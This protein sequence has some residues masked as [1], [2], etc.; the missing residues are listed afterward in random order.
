LQRAGIAAQILA[1]LDPMPVPVFADTP[2]NLA[3]E[4]VLEGVVLHREA[5]CDGVIALGGDAP[6]DLSLLVRLIVRTPPMML[7]RLK[8]RRATAGATKPVLPSPRRGAFMNP[9]I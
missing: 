1:Y 3:E 8:P 5:G 6:I 9:Q 7:R 4:A 2:P